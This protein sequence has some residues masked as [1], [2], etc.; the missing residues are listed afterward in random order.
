MI[1]RTPDVTVT[2]FFS[3]NLI[4]NYKLLIVL[5]KFCSDN[6]V[7]AIATSNTLEGTLSMIII[8]DDQ[9]VIW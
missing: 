6:I 3:A 2:S 4:Q 5:I 1:K 8:S 9:I 7:T